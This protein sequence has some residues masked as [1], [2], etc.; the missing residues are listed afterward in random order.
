MAYAA[1]GIAAAASAAGLLLSF[2]ADLPTGPAV[3]LC[4]GLAWA[5]SVLAG[6]VDSLA[7]RSLRRPH[8]SG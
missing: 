6:P 2:H 5:V 7:A 3:V 4:A 8:L 1:C